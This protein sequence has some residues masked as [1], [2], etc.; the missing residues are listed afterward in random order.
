MERVEFNDAECLLNFR[1]QWGKMVLFTRL[2]MA[3]RGGLCV[4]VCLAA[5]LSLSL[6]AANGNPVQ[7]LFAR[8]C[9]GLGRS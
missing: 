8:V 6:F 1:L 3:E 5:P 2:K 9:R 7:G 4:Y